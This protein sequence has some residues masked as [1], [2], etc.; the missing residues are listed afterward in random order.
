MAVTASSTGA[1]FR[2]S[3]RTIG[4]AA[5]F[6]AMVGFSTRTS[7]EGA[8][9]ALDAGGCGDSTGAATAELDASGVGD[10]GADPEAR[11]VDAHP[12]VASTSAQSSIRI[13][14]IVETGPED[15][16]RDAEAQLL[17][18]APG[19][20]CPSARPSAPATARLAAARLR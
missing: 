3:E 5:A 16:I 7:G 14:H 8:G 2:R 19:P 17:A 10:G 4:N 11:S 15:R 18:T 13:R 9:F 12:L 1:D 20:M 6:T